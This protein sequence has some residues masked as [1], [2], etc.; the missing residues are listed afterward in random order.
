MVLVS[1]KDHSLLFVFLHIPISIHRSFSSILPAFVLH[2]WKECSRRVHFM[3]FWQGY[4]NIRKKVEE[5]RRNERRIENERKTE[6]NCELGVFGGTSD[7]NVSI[8]GLI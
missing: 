7:F 2:V 6:K 1:K 8:D 4:I 3:T 5:K